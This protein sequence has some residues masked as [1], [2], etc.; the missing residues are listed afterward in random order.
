MH[1]SMGHG[2]EGANN[3]AADTDGRDDPTIYIYFHV[4]V[5]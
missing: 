3:D 5:H 4:K 1:R 2:A